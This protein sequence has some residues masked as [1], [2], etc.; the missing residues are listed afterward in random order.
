MRVIKC[1]QFPPIQT[2]RF[3]NLKEEDALEASFVQCFL[4][5][6][7]ESTLLSISGWVFVLSSLDTTGVLS[8][9]VW[10]PVQR[11]TGYCRFSFA[12]DA[13]SFFWDPKSSPLQKHTCTFFQKDSPLLCWTKGSGHTFTL[14]LICSWSPFCFTE[15][16]PSY[17]FWSLQILAFGDVPEF[18]SSSDDKRS[19]TFCCCW[20]NDFLNRSWKTTGV[21]KSECRPNVGG[22]ILTNTWTHRWRG[23]T[24]KYREDRLNVFMYEIVLSCGFIS[25][26]ISWLAGH[27]LF[28]E[29]FLRDKFFS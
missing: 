28:G 9:Y 7:L 1:C 16:C 19:K 15:I 11:N 8:K 18:V 12:P 5:V 6:G 24:L 4:S 13:H 14:K 3:R 27:S 21:S 23:P 10:H 2:D 17:P 29:R 22:F 20:V 26:F 25:A